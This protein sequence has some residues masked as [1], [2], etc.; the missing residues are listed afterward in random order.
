MTKRVSVPGKK[1]RS[2]QEGIFLNSENPRMRYR[3]SSDLIWMSSMTSGV[4][5][6]LCPRMWVFRVGFTPTSGSD[7]TAFLASMAGRPQSLRSE[8]QL[9]FSRLEV[10][11]V[12]QLLACGD[13]LEILHATGSLEVVEVELPGQPRDFVL[14]HFR[15]NGV[16]AQAGNLAADI[17]R[18]VVHRVTEVLAGVAKDDH[19]APLHHEARKR[20]GTAADDDRAAFHV[21]AG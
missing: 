15:R 1:V 17:D 9:L 6:L 7:G 14:G 2:S 10:V 16:H 5:S 18:P 4:N 3:P 12:P 19:A 8:H 20:A 13:L 21:D 11:V